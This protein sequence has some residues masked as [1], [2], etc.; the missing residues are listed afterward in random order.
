MPPWARVGSPRAD[1][2]PA[3]RTVGCE[4]DDEMGKH[5]APK[6]NCSACNGTGK[7]LV[8]TDGQG[9]DTAQQEVDCS[10][11]DGTGKV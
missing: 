7:T 10:V 4:R 3:L 1:G 5:S 11:C 6:S 2:C 9:S 8:T